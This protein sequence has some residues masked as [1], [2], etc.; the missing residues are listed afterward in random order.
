MGFW[1][2][3]KR[4]AGTVKQVLVGATRGPRW[5][6]P[7]AAMA[8]FKRWDVWT[9]VQSSNVVAL[10]YYSSDKAGESCLG[11]Q[12]KGHVFYTYPVPR[13]YYKAA[14]AAPSKGKWTWAAL[15]RTTIPYDGPLT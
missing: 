3:L 8:Y 15:R 7:D 10:A 6:T 1:A 2:S 12:F 4:A 11:I 5:R 14:L 13:T 9:G